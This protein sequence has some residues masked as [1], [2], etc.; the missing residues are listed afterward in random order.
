V[1]QATSF[2]CAR[3]HSQKAIL[4]TIFQSLSAAFSFGSTVLTLPV[5]YDE[6]IWG[7][8]SLVGLQNVL[9][10]PLLANSDISDILCLCFGFTFV[11]PTAIILASARSTVAEYV[12]SHGIQAINSTSLTCM[13][14]RP[15]MASS[16]SALA[17][18]MMLSPQLVNDISSPAKPA[19]SRPHKPISCWPLVLLSSGLVGSRPTMR[20][21]LEIYSALI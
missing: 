14:S 20:L 13:V 5:S 2:L 8:L 16:F 17:W 11:T 1:Y 9:D 19:I 6:P 10:Q 15:S 12:V 18:S 4:T 3:M 21:W 7:N